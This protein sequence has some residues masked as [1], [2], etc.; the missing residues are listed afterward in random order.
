[1]HRLNLAAAPVW[2]SPEQD[3]ASFVPEAMKRANLFKYLNF[4]YYVSRK[5]LDEEI[6]RLNIEQYFCVVCN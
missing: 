1:M 6:G 3:V 5:N 2:R 4:I